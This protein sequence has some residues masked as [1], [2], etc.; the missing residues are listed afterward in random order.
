MAFS[1]SSPHTR[2][3]GIGMELSGIRKDGTPIPVE[4][5]LSPLKSS[6]GE[7]VIAMVRDLTE[8][9]RLKDFGVAALTVAEEERRRIA[10]EL[11][12][13][14]AQE[15]AALLMNL[16]VLQRRLKEGELADEVATLRRRVTV[17]SKRGR[18]DT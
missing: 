1:V 11:H 7:A 14:T 17:L 2:S 8:R 5:S 3:M 18:A 10:R 12:D 6:G 4:T 9:R 16:T 13:Q 15:L